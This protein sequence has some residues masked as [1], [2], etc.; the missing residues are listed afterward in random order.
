MIEFLNWLLEEHYIFGTII[1]PELMLMYSVYK[2]YL[3][4]SIIVLICLMFKEGAKR[5]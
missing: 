2:G 5:K 1:I 4:Q 3:V